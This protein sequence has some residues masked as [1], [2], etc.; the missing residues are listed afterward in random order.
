MPRYSLRTLL[1]LLAVMPPLLWVGWTKYEAWRA[2][3]ARIEV[4]GLGPTPLAFDFAFPTTPTLPAKP[5]AMEPPLPAESEQEF[6]F[7]FG[8]TR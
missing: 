1:I 8:S 4:V 5:Q 3:Q 6:S 7:F 2:A